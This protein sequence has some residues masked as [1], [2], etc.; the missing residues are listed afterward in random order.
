MSTNFLQGLTNIQDLIKE[1][2]AEAT[3]L[4]SREHHRPLP[5]PVQRSQIT[6]DYSY[7]AMTPPKLQL[8]WKPVAIPGTQVNTSHN[9]TSPRATFSEHKAGLT[10][11]ELLKEQNLSLPGLMDS[12]P[13]F[14]ILSPAATTRNSSIN[15]P[16]LIGSPISPSSPNKPP[17]VKINVRKSQYSKEFPLVESQKAIELRRREAQRERQLAEEAEKLRLQ[18]EEDD[19]CYQA[20]LD[21]PYESDEDED[22]EVKTPFPVQNIVALRVNYTS[23]NNGFEWL[24]EIYGCRVYCSEMT[25]EYLNDTY[26]TQP[27]IVC[28]SAMAGNTTRIIYLHPLPISH[29]R[30]FSDMVNSVYVLESEVTKVPP[31][32]YVIPKNPKQPVFNK[33]DR[34]YIMMC[35]ELQQKKFK[36]ELTLGTDDQKQITEPPVPSVSEP[37]ENKTQLTEAVIAEKERV[38]RRE[39]DQ[40]VDD[41]TGSQAPTVNTSGGPFV[42]KLEI[43]DSIRQWV[44]NGYTIDEDSKDVTDVNIL[45]DNYKG[46]YTF[47]GIPPRVFQSYMKRLYPNLWKKTTNKQRKKFTG[48]RGFNLRQ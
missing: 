13:D 28:S 31:A 42:M 5:S 3:K 20:Q 15:S 38:Y 36:I 39:R 7:R 14:P 21:P 41:E 24:G 22:E 30:L 9:L 27:L 32:R 10:T 23:S 45:F 33:E 35:T 48:Y 2:V 44:N 1:Q 26:V 43:A 18:E 19:R 29:Y 40:K 4:K 8:P 46:H 17:V 6:D 12:N 34:P 11:L 25:A 16:P 37:T 47:S